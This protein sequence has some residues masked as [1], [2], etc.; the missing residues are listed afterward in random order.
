MTEQLARIC[1]LAT[2]VLITTLS[3]QQSPGAT[4]L[5]L[6]GIV[7]TANDTPLPRVRVAVAPAPVSAQLARTGNSPVLTPGVLTDERGQFTIRVPASASLWLGFSKARYVSLVAAVSPP[8]LTKSGS[9]IRVQML[10]AGAVSGQVFDRTSGPLFGATVWLRQAGARPSAA[11]LATTTTNDLGEYRFGGLAEGQYVVTARPALFALGGDIADRE[12]IVDA[13][14][15]DSPTVNVANTEVAGVTLMLDAPSEMDRDTAIG[16]DPE[17][18]GSVS[19]RVVG[20]DGVPIARAVV[21]AY[22][23]FVAGRQVE[24]DAR[25]RYQIDRLG[26]GEYIVEA[27]KY[28]FDKSQYGQER[29]ATSGRPVTVK[30]G[31]SVGS[32]DVTLKRGGAISGTIVDEFGEPM[33]GVAVSALELQVTGNRRRAVRVGGTSTD[34]RGHY[35]LFGLKPGTF[36]VEAVVRDA[37]SGTGGYLPWYYPGTSGIDQATATTV[38]FGAAVTG[39]DLALVSTR[40]YRVGGSVADASGKP[41]RGEVVLA[42]SDRSGAI[43]TDMMRTE[44]AA[45]GSFEFTN[46]APGDYV[47]QALG[48]ATPIKGPDGRLAGTQQSQFGMSFVTVS[49]ADPPAL[50]LRVSTGATLL[51]RV[52]YEGLP[53]GPPPFLTLIARPIDR[54]RSSLRGSAPATSD[55]QTSAFELRGVF[56]PTLFRAQPQQSDWY[57][58]AVV[59]KGQDLTDTPFDF[60][61]GTARDIEVVISTLGATARGRVTDDRAAPVR[62][63]TVLVFS[64]S[65]E[66]WFAGSRWVKAERSST[67]AGTFTVTGLP[68]GDYWI[69]AVDRMEGSPTAFV[70][71]ELLDELS[72][73][74]I[75]ITLGEGQS[76]DVPLRLVRR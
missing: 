46:V 32:I 70:S 38:N 72:S 73:R 20:V 15:V 24:T 11:P 40:A 25:G 68:P 5:T 65:R 43:Q 4:L 50:Q 2:S 16:G 62:N 23:P 56:G 48:M 58:K 53:P 55:T 49:A 1:A 27:R 39:V 14:A 51:G 22:R 8:E 7:T 54:D 37:L 76:Q 17:A 28:G 19:G 61:V 9:A 26:P 59:F 63:C 66:K 30:D 44:I 69:A 42:V 60:G 57:L 6:T 21:H 35:R 41:V 74:A 34:D 67:D 10:L 29:S 71:P 33:Q 52:R 31:Q 45:D 13:A 3:A 47:A 36:V 64:T 18:T 75:R 12:K